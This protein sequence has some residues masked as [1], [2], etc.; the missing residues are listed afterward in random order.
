MTNDDNEWLVAFYPESNSWY[1]K[2]VPG[3]FKH[4][5]LFRYS[6]E[7][8][9]WIY[10]DHDFSGVHCFTYPG[11]EEKL[12]PLARAVSKCAI[13]RMKVKPR[14]FCFRGISTC[15]SYVK[16]ALGFNRPWIITPDQLYWA[17]LANGAEHIKS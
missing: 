10:L 1:G 5:A 6:P 2:L 17:L 15:V 9:C 11:V 16:H 8:N 13:V 14:R 4:V 7:A 3:E 12:E